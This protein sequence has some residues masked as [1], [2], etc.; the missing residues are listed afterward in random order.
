LR[1]W[2]LG[3]RLMRKKK[4]VM[5]NKFWV[6]IYEEEQKQILSEWVRKLTEREQRPERERLRLRVVVGRSERDRPATVAERWWVG[7]LRWSVR[8]KDGN[9]K[10]V[11]QTLMF[12][13]SSTGWER[14]REK[15]RRGDERES[16]IWIIW[17]KN[18]VKI[19]SHYC[20]KFT[21]TNG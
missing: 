6:M 11:V 9:W 15:M 19:I 3:L 10:I 4:M 18:K 20:R 16:G 12:C 8:G 1:N 7:F 21:L 5:W 14:D 2:N 17:W 13:Y